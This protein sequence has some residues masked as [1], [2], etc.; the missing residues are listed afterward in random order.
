MPIVY[1][2][3]VEMS[4]DGHIHIDL[5]V[6]EMPFK[7]GTQFILKLIPQNPLNHK[8]FKKR[9]RAFA[10]ECAENNPFKGMSKDE[11]IAELRR[12]REEI[13]GRYSTD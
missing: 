2:T 11:I 12:Q 1:E 13:Y 7:K 5:D 8:V 3:F 10:E 6:D 9:M 4:E